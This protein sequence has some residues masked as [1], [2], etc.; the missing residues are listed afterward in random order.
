M[1]REIKHLGILFADI[2]KS[3]HIYEK[4]GNAKAQALFSKSLMLLAICAVSYKGK[5][6][7]TIG[8]EIMCTFPT[9]VDAIDAAKEMHK[10]LEMMSV[11]EFGINTCPN[12][13]IGVE[14][15]AVILEN[16]DVFGDAVNV[17]RMVS[18][19]K[20]RQTLTTEDTLRKLSPKIRDS[21]RYIDT[22]FIKGKSGKFKIYEIV[23]EPQDVTIMMKP[24][25]EQILSQAYLEIVTNEKRVR[26]DQDHPVLTLGRQT[27]NDIVINSNRISRSHTR[28]EYRKGKFILIDQSTNGTYVLLNNKDSLI[29]RDEIQLLGDGYISLGETVDPDSMNIIRFSISL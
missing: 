23:W 18:K 19:A 26:V 24:P 20:Q 27:Y 28:I 21:A 11:K 9:A 12:I 22:D 7:K 25:V 1:G 29:R 8:D 4:L 3:T 13:Y 6:I 14:F 15:G 2:A 17:A 10:S 16:D 5:V